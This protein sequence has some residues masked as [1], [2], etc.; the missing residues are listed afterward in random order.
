MGRNVPCNEINPVPA[1]YKEKTTFYP[2]INVTGGKQRMGRFIRPMKDFTRLSADK[3]SR[4]RRDAVSASL[5]IKS[6]TRVGPRRIF[7]GDGAMP[8]VEILNLVEN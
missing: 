8:S 3:A 6:C 7:L 4:Y 2:S 1:P 5:T